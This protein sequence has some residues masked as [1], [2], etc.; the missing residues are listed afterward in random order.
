VLLNIC[1]NKSSFVCFKMDS[2]RKDTR[3]RWSAW[4]DSDE[5]APAD[6]ASRRPV[7]RHDNAVYIKCEGV[8]PLSG[9]DGSAWIAADGDLQVEFRSKTIKD[10]V[11][12]DAPWMN[13]RIPHEY[14]WRKAKPDIHP[15][16]T[17]AEL[18][19]KGAPVWL[20]FMNRGI[21][22]YIGGFSPGP[23]LA[24]QMYAAFK[25]CLQSDKMEVYDVRLC[26]HTTAHFLIGTQY[27]G[28]VLYHNNPDAVT[29]EADGVKET[30]HTPDHDDT[31]QPFVPVIDTITRGDTNT[32]ISFKCQ[33]DADFHVR[34]TIPNAYMRTTQASSHTHQ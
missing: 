11:P 34:C 23:S 15:S 16:T 8:Y 33:H 24:Y 28:G 14:W 9:R 20:L 5:K 1:A 10:Y 21:R 22:Q 25:L 31:Y 32:E 29:I 12:F 17:N 26:L 19:A 4:Y 7:V 13:K 18:V 6:D 27:P 30:I 3:V 2:E